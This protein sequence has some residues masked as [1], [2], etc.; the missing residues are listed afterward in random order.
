MALSPLVEPDDLAEWLQQ[1]FSA[2]Q[3]TRAGAVLSRVSAVVRSAAGVTW[4]GEEV[5]EEVEAVVLEVAKRVW[6]NPNGV[7][8][9]A[10]GPFSAS[11]AVVGVYLTDEERRILGKY[12]ANQRGLWTLNT[13]RGD[14]EGDTVWVPV[15]GSDNTF[16]FLTSE[17]V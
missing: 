15:V 3:W 16:P 14:D 2:E 9:Q 5:P 10:T 11:Y 7:R 8:Q 4:E 1:S 17:D 6:T 12:R 13:T